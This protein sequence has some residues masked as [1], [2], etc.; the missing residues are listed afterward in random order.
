MSEELKIEFIPKA[1]QHSEYDW[2]NITAGNDRVGKARCLA[3]GDV[4]TVYSINI[5]PEFEGR[6]YATKFVESVKNKY[7]TI[8]AD[9]VRPTA[10][11][12]WEKVG[13]KKD[14]GGKWIYKKDN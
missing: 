13:F 9:R 10:I 7:D 6:G 2:A 1:Q 5:F 3:E 14:S 4:F 11:G 8:I 12:F